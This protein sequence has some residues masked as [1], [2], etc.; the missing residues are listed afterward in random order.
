MNTYLGSFSEKLN[1]AL[2][3]LQPEYFLIDLHF[4]EFKN[5]TI[6]FDTDKLNLFV[7]L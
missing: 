2:I 1:K 7:V 6:L 5:I 4:Y 3:E